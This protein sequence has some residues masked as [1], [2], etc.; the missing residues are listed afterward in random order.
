MIVCS[1]LFALLAQAPPATS[2]VT[3]TSQPST[4]SG[5]AVLAPWAGQA[6][7]PAVEQ[8]AAIAPGTRTFWMPPEAASGATRTDRVFYF[9]YWVSVFFFVLILALLVYFAI[10]FRRRRVGEA[11]AG[12][13][14]H[15]TGLELTW[16]IIPLILVI[17][18][19]SFGWSAYMDMASPP[20]DALQINVNG[21]KWHWM[22]TYPNGHVDNELHVPVDQ[23]VRLLLT[24]VDVIHSFYVPAFRLKKDAVP[25]RYN[26]A[27]FKA[28]AATP[29]DKPYW[30]LCAEYCGTS[31]SDMLA[32]VYV[33]E[34]GLYEQWLAEASDPFRGGTRSPR[35]VGQM[36][37]TKYGCNTCHSIDGTRGTGPTFKGLFGRSE[38]LRAGQRI[39]VDENYIRESILEPQAK[40]VAGFDPV[41]PTYRGQLK[42]Q[43]ILAL[44]EYIRTL[45]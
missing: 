45:K 15:H 19:F 8:P 30:A 17:C 44:I 22:F 39:D 32:K 29:P 31:H 12:T 43:E 3:T 26:T 34:P 13:V 14:T 9:I 37:F 6:P 16:T 11:A 27:W 42:D 20:A 10:R 23:P 28:T 5:P 1:V 21:Q 4:R 7:T 38:A 33:H 35:E 25:G 24:S 36:L 41:M 2:P 18:M 40:V